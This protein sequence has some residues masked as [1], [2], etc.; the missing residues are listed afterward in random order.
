MPDPTSVPTSIN[1]AGALLFDDKA[2]F[3]AVTSGSV[4][5]V[6]QSYLPVAGVCSNGKVLPLP[7]ASGS[8]ALKVNNVSSRPIV[9]EYYAATTLI[10]GQASAHNLFSIENPSGSGK[11]VIVRRMGVNGV[12]A[13][14]ATALFVY[15]MGRASVFPSGGI[16]QPA[17][18]RLS[19]Q[20]SPVAIV[21]A[22]PA[23]GVS[24]NMW[25]GSP[26]TLITAV[27]HVTSHPLQ[28]AL[29]AVDD[30]GDVVLAPGEA[31]IMIADAND[32]DWRHF[33]SV[34]W[35]EST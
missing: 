19:S 10:A 16:T 11:F 21:R 27:G 13:A 22:S 5:N 17:T 18:K 12:A 9:G 14:V 33:G 8:L 26:G 31:L 35:Q 34:R 32:T 20:P 2:N 25:T 15:R 30:E 24:D 29:D 4:A 23:G 1:F 3:I 6:S 28:L 7:L